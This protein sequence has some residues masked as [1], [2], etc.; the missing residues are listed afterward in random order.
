MGTQTDQDKVKPYLHPISQYKKKS[1]Q[2]VCSKLSK[3][4]YNHI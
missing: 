1:L 3:V 2:K 4:L